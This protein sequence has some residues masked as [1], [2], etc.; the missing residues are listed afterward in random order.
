M[1]ARW[2]GKIEQYDYSTEYRPGRVHGNAD[3][4]RRR[5]CHADCKH[6]TKRDNSPEL[7]RHTTVNA[8]MEDDDLAG[9][10]MKDSDLAPIIEPMK[11]CSV[12]LPGRRS[13]L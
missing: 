7:C 2:L 1:H 9:K 12:G 8:E 6:C 5:P 11:E 10:Q 4:L 13:Q 3:S